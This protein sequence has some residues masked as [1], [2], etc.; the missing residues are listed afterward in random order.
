MHNLSIEE[1]HL[2]G[3]NVS[4]ANLK[5]NLLQTVVLKV[6]WVVLQKEDC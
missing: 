3:G 6:D 1:A 5:C 2:I 4:L